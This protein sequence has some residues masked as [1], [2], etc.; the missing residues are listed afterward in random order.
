MF[1]DVEQCTLPPILN[2]HE[3][4]VVSVALHAMDAT[5]E[6]LSSF[7]TAEE[8]TRAARLRYRKDR[9]AFVA[10]R[11]FL[12]TCLA[13]YLGIAPQ[14]VMFAYSAEG[15]PRL[16]PVHHSTSIQ[17]NL[18]HTDGLA[19]IAFSRTRRVGIDVEKTRPV[20]DELE[21]AE[22][23][24]SPSESAQLRALSDSERRF[25]FLCCWTRKEA[26]AKATGQGLAE[27]LN[28]AR[29]EE[30]RKGA[31]SFHPLSFEPDYVGVVAVEGDAPLGQHVRYD[32]LDDLLPRK[33][34][35]ASS[36]S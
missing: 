4:V 9:D 5:A 31:F 32:S 7:L 3:V 11:V 13:Y 24:F 29:A 8:L 27:T 23:F 26:Y 17:F 34:R 10:S 21:I 30:Q 36:R 16:D 14:E 33:A 18:S 15:K 22:K 28:P 25:A 35:A 20:M 1:A 2:D 19:A 6:S 12:R